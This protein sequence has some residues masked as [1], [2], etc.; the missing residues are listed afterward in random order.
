M[1][2]PAPSFKYRWLAADNALNAPG[3]SQTTTARTGLRITQ[4]EL[5]RNQEL[6]RTLE[7]RVAER[8]RE[9]S[10]KYKERKALIARLEKSLAEV[11]RLSGFLPIC[12]ACKKIR[13]DSGYWSQIETYISTHSQAQFSQSLCPE[14]LHKLYPGL[15]EGSKRG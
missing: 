4:Q 5:V 14:C 1:P 12:S 7:Q 10:D 3:N 11:K 2:W 15:Q 13:D 9:L 6:N 8:T